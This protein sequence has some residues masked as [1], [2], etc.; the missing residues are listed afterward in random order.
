MVWSEAKDYIMLKEVAAEGV[1]DSK[2]GNRDKGTSWQIVGNNLNS[3]PQ[4]SVYSWAI[5][6]G[7]NNIVIDSKKGLIW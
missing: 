6:D 1:F 4:F 5:R 7:F 3:L 2:P